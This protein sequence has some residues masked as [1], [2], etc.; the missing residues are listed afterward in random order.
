MQKIIHKI[1]CLFLFFWVGY[2][3]SKAQIAPDAACS[4]TAPLLTSG[5]AGA[6]CSN[7]TSTLAG[8]ANTTRCGET[9]REGFYRFVATST[10]HTIT[11]QGTGNLDAMLSIGTSC[12][13]ITN[14][15][16]CVN[17]TGNGGVESVTLTSLTV[18]TTYFI[19]IRNQNSPGGNGATANEFN[20]CITRPA[21]PANDNCAGAVSLTQQATGSCTTTSGTVFAATQSVAPCTGAGNSDVWY[22]FSATATSAVV[23]R[24]AGFDSVVEVFSGGCG[25]LTSLGPC[26]DVETDLTITGLT[27]GTTYFVRIYYLNAG[28][29]TTP[30]FTICITT[31]STGPSNDNCAGATTLIHEPFGSCTSKSGTVTAATQSLAG[32]SGTADDD[33]WFSFVATSTVAD[34]RVNWSQDEVVQVFSGSC[35][36]L[37]SVVCQDGGEGSVVTSALTI[38]LT[39]FV[40]VYSFT[41]SVPTYPS[42]SICVT[43]TATAT[44]NNC[45]SSTTLTHSA[46][47]TCNLVAGTF[48]GATSSLADCSGNGYTVRDVWYNFTATATSALIHRVSSIETVIQVFTTGST[49]GALTSLNCF[50]GSSADLQLT[51]LTVGSNYL[52]RIYPASSTAPT[53]PRFTVCVTTPATITNPTCPTSAPICGSNTI[54]FQAVTGG[55]APV[56]N[57]YGCLGSQPAPAWFYFQVATSGSLI[58]GLEASDDIDYAIWGPYNT[59][60]TALAACGTLPAPISCSY[61]IYN[62]E[63]ATIPN[64]LAGQVYVLL[65]TNFANVNQAINLRQVGG[66]GETACSIVLASEINQLT[67]FSQDNHNIITWETIDAQNIKG[68][69]VSKS[70]NGRDFQPIGYVDSN[71]DSKYSFSEVVSDCKDSYYQLQVFYTDGRKIPSKTVSILRKKGDCQNLLQVYPNPTQK[72]ITLKTFQPNAAELEYSLIDTKGR[73]HLAG[74]ASKEAE[75]YELDLST[76]P[77]GLYILKAKI[78]NQWVYEKIVKE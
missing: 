40:R 7:N 52:V 35:G 30:T 67:A 66:T 10:V 75:Y 2:S 38:G 57:N 47:G 20:I 26:Q 61:S 13:S 17:V 5:A 28:I 36:T 25:G 29:P 72:K 78:A 41:S 62:T 58:F 27:I 70:I 12:A 14:L 6:A 22:S 59:Y 50:S 74:K 37:A 71:K 8:F 76:L 34:I 64:A 1:L 21:P 9:S 65:I 19:A 53:D 55:A 39:Y 24:N 73:I 31:P 69:E 45:A 60:G 77:K 48:N 63:N 18:G 16:S 49:C 3:Q 33:V 43:T 11:A 56:G 23:S 51:G 32:C 46:S 4:A 68:F 54:S 42:F 15:A 44:N